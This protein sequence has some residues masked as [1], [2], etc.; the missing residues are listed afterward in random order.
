MVSHNYMYYQ[1]TKIKGSHL[2][3]WETDSNVN[4]VL[5]YILKINVQLTDH[6]IWDHIF[7]KANSSRHFWYDSLLGWEWGMGFAK[8]VAEAQPSQRYNCTI[9]CVENIWE[10]IFY[11]L[12]HPLPP[13]W[14]LYLK[15]KSLKKLDHL[16][17]WT[18]AD[19]LVLRTPFSFFLQ[20][21]RL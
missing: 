5:L 4:T 1:Q 3:S 21:I 6:A 11:F 16:Q 19:F 12:I 14:N 17:P 9:P 20:I 8:F 2:S 15:F 13:C 18:Q 7:Q 10:N